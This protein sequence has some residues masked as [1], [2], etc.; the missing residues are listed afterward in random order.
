MTRFSPESWENALIVSTCF[1]CL[2]YLPLETRGE[3]MHTSHEPRLPGAWE[4]WKRQ[5]TLQHLRLYRR[6]FVSSR[7]SVRLTSCRI[8]IKNGI[9]IFP[10]LRC[11][12]DP[13]VPSHPKHHDMHKNK[14]VIPPQSSF[15]WAHAERPRSGV[16]ERTSAGSSQVFSWRKKKIPCAFHEITEAVR[17]PWRMQTEE[18]ASYDS[19]TADPTHVCA[20]LPWARLCFTHT[21]SLLSCV[22]LPSRPSSRS[23]IT[24]DS[25]SSQIWNSAGMYTILWL[26]FS[27]SLHL[28]VG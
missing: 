5:V 10:H 7:P 25:V 19:R 20:E 21:P 1:V 17:M 2:L 24:S 18:K 13:A 12:A 15:K 26:D 22:S 28:L 23:V 14:P 6:T 8:Q 27:Q 16:R 4:R 9:R 3:I 11:S